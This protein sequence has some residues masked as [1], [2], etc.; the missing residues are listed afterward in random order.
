MKQYYAHHHGRVHS[1]ITSIARASFGYGATVKNDYTIGDRILG[2]LVIARPIFLILTPINA[3]G[4]AVLAINRFPD[5]FHCIM[6][7][8]T[9]ALAGSA[10]NIFN[11][12]EDRE[13]DKHLWQARPIPSGRIKAYE[14]LI[15]VAVLLVASLTLCWFLFNITTWLILCIAIILGCLYSR[16]FRDKIGYLSLPPIVG[17]IYLLSFA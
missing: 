13:R 7:L 11:D 9:V 12:F 15:Y 2:F 4:A 14:S 1:R 5:L 17:L 6:G 8:L 16:Y 3:A 10:I